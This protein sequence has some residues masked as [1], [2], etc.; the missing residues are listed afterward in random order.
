MF[1]VR[2][3][4]LWLKFH[5]S[6]DNRDVHMFINLFLVV[7]NTLTY[8]YELHNRFHWRCCA[9]LFPMCK[10]ASVINGGKDQP[11]MFF[12]HGRFAN[13]WSLQRLN[14]G[15]LSGHSLSPN[16]STPKFYRRVM[17]SFTSL[18]HPEV[19]DWYYASRFPV[20][21]GRWSPMIQC[22]GQTSQSLLVASEIVFGNDWG[23]SK[24]WDSQKE[25]WRLNMFF[26][27]SSGHKYS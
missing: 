23:W 6:P 18:Q 5:E 4:N 14:D 27:I 15:I 9:F 19:F 11:S 17:R 1:G 26:M 8:C 3:E 16:E 24:N 13:I 10:S 22:A 7:G 20:V 2:F 25:T 12:M 21:L